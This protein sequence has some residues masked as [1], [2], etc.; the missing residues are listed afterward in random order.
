[1][2][3]LATTLPARGS[4]QAATA[5][6]AGSA[7]WPEIQA[8]RPPATARAGPPAAAPS[9]SSEEAADRPS[10]TARR[11]TSSSPPGKTLPSPQSSSAMA[12]RAGVHRTSG[13]T[14]GIAC[15]GS[16]TSGCSGAT[17]GS[18][19]VG[20]RCMKR[21]RRSARRMQWPDMLSVGVLGVSGLTGQRRTRW[22]GPKWPLAIAEPLNKARKA[23][24]EAPVVP[25]QSQP[26]GPYNENSSR[27]YSAPTSPLPSARTPPRWPAPS[28][29]A[30]RAS[31][32]SRTWTS[33]SRATA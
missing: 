9:S 19:G 21:L 32:T 4:R 24:S 31:T 13:V 14:A 1:M 7:S 3:R 5:A 33:K 27:T 25:S 11:S 20:R 8:P 12:M 18:A 17:A 30:A 15:A 6:S 16:A 28:T 29:C 2:A 22:V 10:G 23:K 26:E